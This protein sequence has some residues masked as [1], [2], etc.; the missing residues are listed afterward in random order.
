[1]WCFN[2][3]WERNS[4]A[5]T[6]MNRCRWLLNLFIIDRSNWTNTH[7]LFSEEYFFFRCVFYTFYGHHSISIHSFLNALSLLQF[8]HFYSVCTR[9]YLR[10]VDFYSVAF[11][12][13][14]FF[15][16]S[17]VFVFNG[18]WCRNDRKREKT[19]WIQEPRTWS[20]M[21]N[22]WYCVHFCLIFFDGFFCVDA[23]QC[24]KWTL[25]VLQRVCVRCALRS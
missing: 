18:F 21:K 17:P 25:C 4:S 6:W 3:T 12:R 16:F 24:E 23:Q 13:S 10:A 9:F 20:L 2:G 11:V 7:C 1:M 5:Y 22:S 19:E 14:L 15:L 8:T